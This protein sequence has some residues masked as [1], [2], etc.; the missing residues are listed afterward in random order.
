MYNMP[1]FATTAPSGLRHSEIVPGVLRLG[2]PIVNWYL[3]E[4]GGRLTAVDAGLPGYG[5]SLE[6]D[7]ATLGL[8]LD[9]IDAVV[10]THSDGDHTGLAT[11]MRAAGARVLIHADDA[12]GLADP[13]PKT[14]DGT[15]RRL[16]ALTL[17]RPR[18]WRFLGHMARNG[19]GKPP[20]ID[21]G[22]TFVDGERLDVPGRP[23]VIHTPGHTDGHSALHFERH[24]T[25][26][27]GD[28]LCTRNP[29]T[30]ARGPQVMPK[31]CNVS[32]ERCFASLGAIEPVAADVVLPGHGDP[33]RG[34]P[35]AAVAHARR[36]AGR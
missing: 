8:A 26:V 30:G 29:A 23:L 18:M 21:D 16:L 20:R 33:W 9:R 7:L 31:A 3:V 35:A 11:R 5:S 6:A 12:G 10:L 4:D 24:G 32:W 28:A 27:V 1:M 25:L 17:R 15:P 13:G 22:E 14:G 19:G 36:V 34:S 2:T